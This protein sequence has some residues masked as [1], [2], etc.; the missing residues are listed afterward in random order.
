MAL[1]QTVRRVRAGRESSSEGD[2]ER[3]EREIHFEKKRVG[4]SE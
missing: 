4:R 2:A 1:F 3:E